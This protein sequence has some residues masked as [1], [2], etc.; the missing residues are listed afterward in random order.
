MSAFRC[1]TLFI[2]MSF[3]VSTFAAETMRP[4]VIVIYSDDQGSVDLGCYG[5]KDILSPNLDGLAKTGIR[6][7]QMYAPAPV[8]SASRAGLMTGKMPTR[9][10]VPGNV[11]CMFG[12]PGMPTEQYTMAELF[13]D[14]GYRTAL[15]G[16]WHLGYSPETMP[17]AQGFDE[18]YGIMGGVI[19]NW[20]H[21]IYWEGACRHDLWKNGKEIFEPGQYFPRRMTDECIDF[22]RRNKAQPFFTYVAYTIAHYPVQPLTETMEAY[23]N[24]P[25]QE[26]L[27]SG[28]FDSTVDVRRLYTAFVTDMD[29]QIG[30]IIDTLE[31]EGLRD[32]TI[33]VFQADQ[34]HSFEERTGY[35]GGWAGPY[36]GGKFSLYEGG[37]RVPS[38]V[39][40][41][42]SLQKNVVRD[43]MLCAID[44]MP[45]LA[46]LCGVTFPE[47]TL[48][49]AID[50][51]SFAD[52][53]KDD[54]PS[55]HE[56]LYW[57][58]KPINQQWAVRK[59]NWKLLFN[60]IDVS[61][62]SP[63]NMNFP[64][65]PQQAPPSTMVL[66]DLKADP[67]ETTN[68]AEKYPSIVEELNVIR[69]KYLERL[70]NVSSGK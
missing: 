25:P 50:G 29:T 15:F 43:Q 22:I 62:P 11:S 18:H 7:T 35:G 27:R 67:G 58:I 51:K 39:S 33:I 9:A 19:D 69:G 47:P 61:Q 53:L 48:K 68:L 66:V 40:W 28:K 36:R 3:S 38:L 41:P 34:G 37:I 70:K 4:N 59:G 2:V 31:K 6:F 65:F 10:G 64:R 5:T 23:E 24:V 42:K 54:G 44:W 20:S 63:W 49:E 52:V 45:T 32:N 1:L 57:D 17:A 12:R 46:E 16:K 21:Y 55:P 30:R 60:P 26:I 8:C 14:A 13:H 56:D